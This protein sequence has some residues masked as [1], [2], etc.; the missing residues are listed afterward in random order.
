[1]YHKMTSLLQWIHASLV[2]SDIYKHL[3]VPKE[4]EKRHKLIWRSSDA[5][6]YSEM[7]ESLVILDNNM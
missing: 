4:P 1:M 5:M 3:A 2:N 6:S 7:R